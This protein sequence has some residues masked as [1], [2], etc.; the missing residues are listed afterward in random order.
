MRCSNCKSGG[1]VYEYGSVEEYAE[2][3]GLVEEKEVT[4]NNSGC[5]CILNGVTIQKRYN[6]WKK[7]GAKC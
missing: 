6:E 1:S 3:C 5:G 2:V 4:F 7:E